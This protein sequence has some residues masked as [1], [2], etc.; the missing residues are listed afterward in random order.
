[1]KEPKSTVR[2]KASRMNQAELSSVQNDATLGRD[3]QT[4]IGDQLRAMYEE[5]VDQGVPDRFTQLLKRLD[6]QGGEDRS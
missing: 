6:E 3:I 4:Q 2:R 5:V 1:M